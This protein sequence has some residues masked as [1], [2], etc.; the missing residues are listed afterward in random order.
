MHSKAHSLIKTSK[1]VQIVKEQ[2]RKPMLPTKLFPV[3]TLVVGGAR[4]DRTADLLRARQALSQLSYGPLTG[5]FSVWLRWFVRS[6]G[7]VLYV[8]SLPHT[9]TAL[10][11][12]KNPASSVFL[13]P[14]EPK[15][16]PGSRIFQVVRSLARRIACYASGKDRA[17]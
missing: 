11:V 3:A 1:L 4:R 2:C 12:E 10:P 9:Q 13:T 6:G 8:R 17:R 5:L 7:H 16:L 15:L 14:V